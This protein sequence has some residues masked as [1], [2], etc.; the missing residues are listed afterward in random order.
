MTPEHI[1]NVIQQTRSVVAQIK[2]K[3]YRSACICGSSK[4]GDLIAVVKWELEKAG[5]MATGLHYLPEWYATHAGWKDEHHGAEQE[6]VDHILDELHIAKIERYQCI[7]V[8]N[9]MDILA[10]GLREK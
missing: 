10:T 3:K 2:E 5:I 7:L 9:A 8:V 4:F 1:S 6:N